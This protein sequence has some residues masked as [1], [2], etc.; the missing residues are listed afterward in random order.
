MVGRKMGVQVVA[1]GSIWKEGGSSHGNVFYQGRMK[2]WPCSLRHR[3][4]AR[5]WA[6]KDKRCVTAGGWPSCPFRPRQA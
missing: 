1:L 6:S 5:N 2:L 4:P 3:L